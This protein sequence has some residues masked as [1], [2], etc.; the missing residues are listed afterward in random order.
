LHPNDP[1]QE[2]KAFVLQGGGALGA[3]EAGV[4]KAL[5]DRFIKPRNQPFDIFAGV[6][7]GAVNASILVAMHYRITT[8][9]MNLWRTSIDFGTISP[10]PRYLTFC[11]GLF[12]GLMITQ[13]FQAG[14]YIEAL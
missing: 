7:I 10:D 14:G 2:Q 8:D 13:R 12:T 3:Y 1:P 6:S 9:G 4:Y 11:R 5:Y